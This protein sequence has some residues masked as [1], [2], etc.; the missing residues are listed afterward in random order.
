[1]E[2]NKYR[3]TA[4][5]IFILSCLGYF[6]LIVIEK[7]SKRSA[8]IEQHVDLKAIKKRGVL[9]AITEYNSISYF[10]YK[11]QPVGFDYELMKNFAKS[12]GVKLEMVVAKNTDDMY[13]LLQEGKG[14]VIANGL[15][16]QKE[17]NPQIEYSTPYRQVEQVIVQRT[18]GSYTRP[19]DSIEVFAPQI[20]SALDLNKKTI[21]VGVNSPYYYLLKKIADTLGMELDLRV[22][23]DDRSTEDLVEAVSTAEIDYTIADK[24]LALVNNSYFENLDVSVPI[25]P[26]Q[27]LH[28]AVRTS[29]AALLKAI[30][31]WIKNY[32]SSPDY[33]AVFNKYFKTDKGIAQGFDEENARYEQGQISSYDAIIQKYAR[34]MNWDWRLIAAL[35][36]QE[37]GF[38]PMATS[39]A[40]AQG[41]MQLMPGTSRKMGL[42]PTQAY[43]PEYNIRAG[44]SYLKFLED[45]WKDIPNFTQRT[46]FII[47]SYNAGPGHVQDAA[48]LAKKYGYPDDQWDGAVE[49]FILYTSNPH[50]YTDEVVKFGYCRGSETFN[51]VRSIVNKYF[52][53]KD[54]IND[55]T[56]IPQFALIRTE[57]IPF[58]GVSG[59]YN[60]TTG[61][62]ARDARRELFISQKLFE[63]RTQLKLRNSTRYLFKNNSS[64]FDQREWTGNEGQNAELFKKRHL[65]SDSVLVEQYDQLQPKNNYNINSMKKQPKKRSK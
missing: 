49:Y 35:I 43:N 7:Y 47:A 57:E 30:N 50:F 65:F 3:L 58:A 36:K 4:F 15:L 40:G 42:F 41:L 11:G 29:S 54:R 24:D 10:I 9:R 59:L 52:N 62:I 51:Y 13:T 8:Y 27:D 39:W 14:D 31:N 38:N 46:K 17:W 21:Y 34:R 12:L 63:V 2:L 45:Y 53:Y 18:P 64:L 20:K 5:I 1:L 60:P 37:S 61:L 44:T 33:T 23:G 16:E 22:I 28:Y 56:A 26:S 19:G 25:G 55:S 48:R 6:T 32:S